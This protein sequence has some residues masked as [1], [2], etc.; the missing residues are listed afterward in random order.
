MSKP[1]F[2]D[3]VLDGAADPVVIRKE[4]TGEWWMFYTNRRANLGTP[5]GGWIQGSPIGYAAST[6]QG[7][8]WDY[9]GQV[10][11]LDDPAHPGLNTHWAPEIIYGLGEYHMYLSYTEGA[12]E[13]FDVERHIVHYTSPNLIDWTRRSVLPLNSY[14]VIDAA[15]AACPDGVYRLWYK[16]ELGG[17]A[18]WSAISTN[19]YDWTLEG[20]VIPGKPDGLPHEGPNVFKL[21]GKI[22]LIV[23][24]WHGMGAFHSDDAKTWTRQGVILAEPGSD[25]MDRCYARHGDVVVQDGFAELFYFTHPEWDEHAKP[26]PETN[27]E[28]RTVIHVARLTVEDGVLLANRNVE[29]RALVP[30]PQM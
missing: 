26:V 5:G 25:P 6:D 27:T 10:A 13:H 14:K 15:V 30:H 20:M 9:R 12:P 19:L 2:V 8:S 7:L 21:G 28:R 4:G 16:D 18:T 3:P 17:S 29:P 22:W 23:D 1:I 11:G 24:E